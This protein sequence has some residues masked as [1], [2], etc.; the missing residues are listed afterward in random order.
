MCA[1][2]AQL[3]RSLTASQIKGPGLNPQPARVLNFGVPSV[4]TPSVDRNVKP[5]VWSVEMISRGLKRTP[6]LFTKSTVVILVFGAVFR[7]LVWTV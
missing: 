7:G 4:V 1:C 3:V 2:Q 6:V 5:L